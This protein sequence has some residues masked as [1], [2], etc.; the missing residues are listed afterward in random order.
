[1]INQYDNLVGKTIDQ[2]IEIFGKK[3]II[4]QEDIWVYIMNKKWY[5][6]KEV[7]FIIMEKQI[8]SIVV[9]KFLYGDIKK[10]FK[11]INKN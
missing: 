8:V 7:L 10:L 6:K 3:A 1:M 5:G 9:I 2:I 11:Q 4:L